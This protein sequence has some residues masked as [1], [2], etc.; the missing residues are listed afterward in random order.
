MTFKDCVKLSLRAPLTVWHTQSGTY[1][2]RQ[3]WSSFWNLAA[4][5]LWV[6]FGLIVAV[7]TPV[8]ALMILAH[9]HKTKASRAAAA[10]ERKRQMD[11]DI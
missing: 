10:A 2:C 6:T 4:V 3:L 7:S 8:V 1:Y 11:A 5:L 9:Y